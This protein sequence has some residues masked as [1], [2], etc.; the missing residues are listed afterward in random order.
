MKMISTN[1]IERAYLILEE[2]P[3]MQCK[4]EKLI[5]VFAS[6]Q[7]KFDSLK[8]EDQA[9]VM[10]LSDNQTKEKK[11]KTLAGILETNVYRYEESNNSI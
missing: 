10:N 6:Y 3:I 4:D 7:A 9:K 1:K 8:P 2:K 11:E 5:S